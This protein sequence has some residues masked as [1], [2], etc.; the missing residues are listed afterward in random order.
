MVQGLAAWRQG[1]RKRAAMPAMYTARRVETNHWKDAAELHPWFLLLTM[2]LAMVCRQGIERRGREKLGPFLLGLTQHAY[3]LAV[4]SLQVAPLLRGSGLWQPHSEETANMQAFLADLRSSACR[5]YWQLG[6]DG[7]AQRLAQEGVAEQPDSGSWR[8]IQAF[9]MRDQQAAYQLAASSTGASS[10]N[11]K[12]IA[13]T[14]RQAGAGSSSSSR[15][16]PRGAAKKQCSASHGTLPQ[17][18]LFGSFPGWVDQ[19]VSQVVGRPVKLAIDV[20][21]PPDSSPGTMFM[22]VKP[23]AEVYLVE[24][25]GSKVPFSWWAGPGG[26]SNTTVTTAAAV[27]AETNPTTTTG[28]GSDE[29]APLTLMPGPLPAEDVYEKYLLPGVADSAQQMQAWDS[30]NSSPATT[31]NTTP[32]NS[33][34]GTPSG[35][36][37][38]AQAAGGSNGSSG[39]NAPTAAAA[40]GSSTSSSTSRASQAP[41]TRPMVSTSISNNSMCFSFGNVTMGI[42]TLDGL[43]EMVRGV[44]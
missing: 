19:L 12:N 5:V 42:M 20:E 2:H 23:H 25:D 41:H 15:P 27:M 6:N 24:A 18:S 22:R 33:Q 14:G 4:R 31:T 3:Q 9:L 38:H 26:S 40:G 32:T 29:A 44:R 10:P 7:M 34:Q 21:H 16:S 8:A 28:S 36:R 39:G 17:G 13:Y 30:A 1:I 43:E 37:G 11:T 35:G